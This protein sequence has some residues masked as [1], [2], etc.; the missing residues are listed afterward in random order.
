MNWAGRRSNGM[1]SMESSWLE[2][3]GY[4]DRTIFMPPKQVGSNQPAKGIPPIILF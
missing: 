2:K 3:D 1:G 4:A